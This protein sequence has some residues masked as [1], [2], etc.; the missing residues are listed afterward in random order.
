MSEAS[1]TRSSKAPTEIRL[2]VWQFVRVMVQLEAASRARGRQSAPSL[3]GA[4]RPAWQEI[5]RRLTQ[6]GKTDAAAFSE[7]MMEQEVVLQCRNRTQMSELVRTLDNVINQLKSEIKLA[8]GDAR[9]LT[10]LRFERT[11]LETLSRRLRKLAR[12]GGSSAPRARAK[13]KAQAKAG[14]KSKPKPKARSKSGAKP[15]GR[16]PATR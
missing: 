7:L 8:S 9:R 16:R 10:D 12:T 11:E 13:P 3:Y 4:W 6:V 15:S 1:A 14:P 5:D 2:V